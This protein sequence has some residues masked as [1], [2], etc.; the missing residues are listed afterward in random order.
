M[1][2]FKRKGDSPGAVEVEEAAFLVAEEEEEEGEE[3][4]G[5]GV[6]VPSG[7]GTKDDRI[8]S[9]TRSVLWKMSSGGACVCVYVCGGERR[10]RWW[11]RGGR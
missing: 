3:G 2:S 4:S 6:L 8:R 7:A 5:A 1:T 10:W 9:P 11:W